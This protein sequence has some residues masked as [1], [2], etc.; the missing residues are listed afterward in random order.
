[1]FLLGNRV[2]GGLHGAAP[3]L[4]DLDNANLRFTTDFRSVYATV[5]ESWLEASA[6]DVLGQRFDQL[7]LFAV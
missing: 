3:S 6:A 1:M 2:K 7:D 5:L 4:T